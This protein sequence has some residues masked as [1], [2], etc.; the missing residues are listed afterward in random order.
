MSGSPPSIDELRARAAREGVTPRTED[1]ERVQGY[2]D[3]FVRAFVELERAL[4]PETVPA[5]LFRPEAER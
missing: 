1:L 2:V 3:A 5:G 4:P